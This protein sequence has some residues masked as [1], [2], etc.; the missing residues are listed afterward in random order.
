MKMVLAAIGL[1]FFIWSFIAFIR[2]GDFDE[3]SCLSLFVLLLFPYVGG[4]IILAFVAEQIGD[5]ESVFLS[6]AGLVLI[7]YLADL[8]DKIMEL[9]K[10]VVL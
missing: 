8:K 2:M 7:K 6:V 9:L 5:Y 10:P 1:D 4:L 3:G